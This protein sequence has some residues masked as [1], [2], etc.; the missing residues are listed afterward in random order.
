MD[1]SNTAVQEPPNYNAEEMSMFEISM[2]PR[3]DAGLEASEVQT[4]EAMEAGQV[5]VEA[6]D[7][8]QSERPELIQESIFS[9]RNL[10]DYL[11]DEFASHVFEM[12][13]ILL[14]HDAGSW[15]QR[16]K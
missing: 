1:G 3:M 14:K 7:L 11:L 12:L 13:D 9:F 8:T 16:K 2:E 4:I 5:G 10:V 6:L 15:Y